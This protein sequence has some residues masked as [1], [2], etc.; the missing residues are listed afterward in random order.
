MHAHRRV[1]VGSS[2]L[3]AVN[4]LHSRRIDSLKEPTTRAVIL[5][6]LIIKCWSFCRQTS[7]GV[8]CCKNAVKTVIH[9]KKRIQTHP[10]QFVRNACN[11]WSEWFC[12]SVNRFK[13][14]AWRLQSATVLCIATEKE[15][16]HLLRRVRKI[17]AASTSNSATTH[18]ET[19]T[20]SRTKE[21]ECSLWV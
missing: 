10:T 9:L 19:H 14:S 6:C 16:K 17:W 2:F 7:R 13:P 1:R 12:L 15:I 11:I 8:E 4:P 21:P 5:V 18:Q 20:F 3:T